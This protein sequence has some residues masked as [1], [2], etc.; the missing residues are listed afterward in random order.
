VSK[1]PGIGALALVLAACAAPQPQRPVPAIPQVS[2]HGQAQPEAQALDQGSPGTIYRVDETESELR[3]LVYRAGPLARLGHNHVMVNRKLLGTVNVAGAASPGAAVASAFWLSVPSA[4]F[5]V[6]DAQARAEEGAD[7]AAAVTDDAKSGT[8]QNMLSAA[9]LDAAEYPAI[10]V[11]SVAVAGSQ[12]AAAPGATSATDA[13]GATDATGAAEATRTMVASVTIAVA[14]HE[15]TMDV[16]FTLQMESGR[17]SATG[18][19]ELRQSALG[20]TPYS[21]M[22]GALQVQDQMT[23]KFKIVARAS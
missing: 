5:D 22:L 18:T 21:L 11:R 8:L 2:T 7:F 13:A 23:I 4:A 19:L 6:D 15:S 16:P 14:G 9:V 17:L 3:I 20:V 12:G 10:T 1:Y